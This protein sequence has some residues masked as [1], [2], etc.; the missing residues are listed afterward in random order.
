MHW[1]V[2][3]RVLYSMPSSPRRPNVRVTWEAIVSGREGQ[4]HEQAILLHLRALWPEDKF[5]KNGHRL[6]FDI[7]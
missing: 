2:K 4:H 7:S 6:T 3:E 1:C 5:L